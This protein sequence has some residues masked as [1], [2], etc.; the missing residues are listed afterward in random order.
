M[1]EKRSIGQAI[2]ALLV[3]AQLPSGAYAQRR[4]ELVEGLLRSFLESQLENE[5]D[6]AIHKQEL[7]DRQ[8]HG[9][10]LEPPAPRRPGA[11]AP[12]NVQ[13]Y[14]AKL[15][16]LA[17]QSAGLTV[18][19]QKSSSRVR[20]VQTLMP[21]ALTLKT[22][23]AVMF[24]QS[25]KIQDLSLLREEYRNLDSDWRTLSFQLE[26]LGGLDA[27]THTHVRQMNRHCDELCSLLELESQFDREEV[28][29]LSVETT[30]HLKTLIEDIEFELYAVKDS[31]ILARE[32]RG[33]A[34]QSRRVAAM[35]NVASYEELVTN[36]SS[37]VSNWRRFAVKLYPHKNSHCARSI[38]RIHI[39]NQQV[40][41]QLWTPL[42]LDRDYLRFV[43]HEMSDQVNALFENMSVRTL[44]ELPAS[45]QQALLQTAREL[46]G[47]CEHYCQCVD[48][49]SS[50]HELVSDYR[51][52]DQQWRTLDGYMIQ[53][54]TPIIANGRRT[55]SG[56]NT[57]LR[58]LMNVPAQF[59]RAHALELAASLQELAAH[60][61]YDTR[62][63]GRYY[64]NTT[65]RNQAYQRSEAFL[66]QTQTLHLHLQQG[67]DT[68]ALRTS[69]NGAVTAWNDY[70]ETLSAMP[71]NGLSQ[72]RNQVFS[73]SSQDVLPVIAELA[74][75]IIN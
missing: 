44:V 26:R 29:T 15:G 17:N 49:N 16:L 39:A 30:T 73:A 4:G 61:H 68:D 34:E 9:P 8:R 47:L 64:N 52:I 51:Q 43:S 31:P 69:C 70:S 6:Q 66:K 62:R 28:F 56:Y 37:L 7:Q 38:R 11:P 63:Y 71:R 59:D 50:L 10:K 55:V 40:F 41:E 27:A 23:S 60:L 3:V 19:M 53:I 54:D 48:G 24:Q 75:L 72:E 74:T 22:R 13:A 12:A 1:N 58:D 21:A 65:F 42:A 18:A 25:T 32:C 35:V 20:G 57:E 46:Y 36:C 45:E 2:L 5:R 14:R 33:L 67:S